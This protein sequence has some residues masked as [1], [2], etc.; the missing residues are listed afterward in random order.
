MVACALS[1]VLDETGA[2]KEALAQSL[3]SSWIDSAL[4]S[5]IAIVAIA[6]SQTGHFSQRRRILSGRLNYLRKLAVLVL[7]Y[8]E[9]P[10]K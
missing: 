7:K 6:Q 5:F 8:L 10:K 1:A 3:L 2:A 4:I 9:L